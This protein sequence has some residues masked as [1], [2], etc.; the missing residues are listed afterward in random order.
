LYSVGPDGQSDTDDDIRLPTGGEDDKSGT[1]GT[2]D[3]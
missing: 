3:Q 2:A 1:K